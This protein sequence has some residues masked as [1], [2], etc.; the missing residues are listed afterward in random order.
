MESNQKEKHIK[1]LL[2]KYPNWIGDAVMAIPFVRL[3][4][5]HFP[6]AA[7]TVLVKKP[8]GDLLRHES[9]VSDIIEYTVTGGLRDIRGKY[10]L[11]ISLRKRHFD[12]VLIMP[13]SFEAALWMVFAGIPQRI[14]LSGRFRSWLLTDALAVPSDARTHHQ[15]FLYNHLLSP[16]NKRYGH[17]PSPSQEGR[18]G[19]TPSPSQEGRHR[20]TPNFFDVHDRQGLGCE[21]VWEH[22]P[23]MKNL[24][25]VTRDE[26]LQAQHLLSQSSGSASGEKIIV[27]NPSA[28]YG[29]AKMWPAEYYRALI[30]KLTGLAHIK[31][32]VIGKEAGYPNLG[33]V[34]R[35]PAVLDVRGRTDIR[36]LA[37]VLKCSDLLITND[38]GPMHIAAGV[39]TPILALFGPTNYMMTAPLGKHTVIQHAVSCSPCMKR[40][41]MKD[42]ICMKSISVNEVYQKIIEL[43]GRAGA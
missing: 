13:R 34:A 26:L 14:G 15:V 20:H 3:A 38:T 37:A 42:H 36:G 40:V 21:A 4:A 2:I 25:P 29:T 41:C 24:I 11:I 39:G 27:L 12:C 10:Q 17:T 8:L 5:E 19:H 32:V 31:V 18:Y 35:Q 23:L 7:I 28:S 1:R 6:R 33:D 43:T 16:L 30:E 9:S 22:N